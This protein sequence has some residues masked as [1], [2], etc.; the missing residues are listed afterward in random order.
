MRTSEEGKLTEVRPDDEALR[1]ERRARVLAAMEAEGVDV[2][3]VGREGNA[4]YVSGAPR[5]WTAGSRPFGPGCVLVRETGA[6]HF[7]STWDEGIPREIPHENL[8]G[9]SFNSMNLLSALQRIQGA[10]SARTVATDGLTHT[11]AKLLTKAFPSGSVVDGEPMLRRVRRTKL[12][13][14]VEAI[15]A[16]VRVAELSMGDAA[17]TLAPGSTGRELTGAFMQAMATRGVTTPAAQDVAWISSRDRRG[18]RVGRDAPVGRGDLVTFAAGVIRGGYSGELGRTLAAGDGCE[19]DR[20][21]SKRC[22]ELWHRLLAACSRPGAPFSDLLDAYA[23]A[24]EPLPPMPVA[25]GLGLG[26]DL[27]L[28]TDALPRSAAEERVEAGMVIA[29]SAYV[30]QEGVGAL[31]VQEPVLLTE[32][33]PVPLTADPFQA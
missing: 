8:Y 3:V 27:P 19:V 7:L 1:L 2:L 29:L 21:L 6:V 5:L 26:F 18:V 16:S 14:E 25:H 13:A 22:E 31:Y 20:G 11:W 10:D 9:I 17:A 12:P 30:W 28:V 4:R 15:R 24:G 33:G 23:S 32:T